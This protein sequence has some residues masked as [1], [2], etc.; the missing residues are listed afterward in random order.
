MKI[1]IDKTTVKHVVE[2][3]RHAANT[4]TPAQADLNFFDV[5][6]NECEKALK[7]K[8]TGYTQKIEE[9][10]KE[11]DELKVIQASFVLSNTIGD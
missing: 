6:I 4:L 2:A 11:R 7:Q 8:E 9:L 1:L 3:L 10:I 5:V